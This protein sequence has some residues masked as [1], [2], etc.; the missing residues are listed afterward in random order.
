MSF[1]RGYIR[2]KGKKPRDPFK[3]APLRSFNQVKDEE[4]YAGVLQNDTV[5]IDIDD[6]KQAETLLKI[7]QDKALN[8]QVRQT[9]RGMHFYFVNDGTWEKC[10][11]GVTLAIGLTADIKVGVTNCYAVLKKEGV[12]R[13]AIYDVD[14]GLFG[15]AEYQAPP[16]W[17][18]PVK[19]NVSV[20]NMHEG[21]GRNTKLFSYILSFLFGIR[22][23]RHIAPPKNKN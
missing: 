13:E 22:D 23:L 14:G 2:L 12:T 21:E 20:F 9:T 8:C 1:F 16:K 4:S 6:G 3:N 15:G 17:L 10:A 11:T 7:V 5:L 19:T 18:H